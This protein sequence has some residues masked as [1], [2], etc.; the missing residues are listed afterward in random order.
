MF[1]VLSFSMLVLVTLASIVIV[2]PSASAAP[3]QIS[4]SA[5]AA[6]YSP[7]YWKNWKNHYTAQE[8]QGIVSNTIHFSSLT[9]AEAVAILNNNR[10]Q[11]QRHLLSA[12]L[13]AAN[14]PSFAYGYY[15]YGDL[16]ISV[17]ELLDTAYNTSSPSANLDDAIR[18][19]GSNGEGASSSSCRVIGRI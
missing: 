6:I 5:C 2:A 17:F 16:F 19:I 13:N 14:D 10:N 7:G 12:E 18:Y 9:P 1:R 8:F 15:V 3:S 4:D 11:F